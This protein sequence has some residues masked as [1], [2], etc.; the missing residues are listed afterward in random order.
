[1]SQL[2]N[3]I[4]GLSNENNELK[5]ATNY[6]TPAQLDVVVKEEKD[7]WGSDSIVVEDD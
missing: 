4:L 1:M 5:S 7:G 2:T 6:V 3:K